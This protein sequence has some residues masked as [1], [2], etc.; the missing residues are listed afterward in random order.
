[1]KR[2]E[3][4]YVIFGCAL[5]AGVARGGRAETVKPAELAKVF[6]EPPAEAR[7]WVFW[8]W[9][10]G[11]VSKAGITADLEAMK[12]GGVAGAYL[13]PI[14]DVPEKPLY[15]P[16][17]RTLTPAWWEM[18]R[19]AFAEADRL[20][21]RL[22]MQDCDGFATAGGPWITPDL[23]MQKL[24]WSATPVEGGAATLDVALA[25]PATNEGFYR[26]VAVLAVPRPEGWGVTTRTV[27]P[28][29]T[30]SFA[31]AAQAQFLVEPAGD[32]Q[33]RES[34]PGWVQ[35]A[36]AEP[37]TL[38]SLTIR[39]WDHNY[40]G[41]YQAARLAIEVSDDGKVFREHFRLTPPR[42][43]WQDW[44]A[45]Y[46]FAVP[47]VTARYF[48]FVY[49][50][51]GS[52]EGSEELDAAKWKPKL[53]LRGLELSAAARVDD[54][55]GK[56]GLAWRRSA[57]TTGAQLPGKFCVLSGQVTDLRG[58]VDGTG[59]LRWKA[60]AGNWLVLRFGYT[61]TGHRNETAG[62][63]M[64]LEADKL[65]GKAA[66][67]QFE[68][69]F[70][71]TARRV[72][73]ELAARVLKVFH[74][75]SWEAG[76]QN[77]TPAFREEFERRRGFDPVK[78]LPVMAGIGIDS[79]DTSERFL[80]QVRQTISDLMTEKFFGTLARLAHEHGCE[81]SAEATAPTMMGD[82]MRH[83]GE[84]DLP[85]GEFWL[86]S[87][88][89]DKPND[90]ADAVSGAHVY[91]RRIAQAEAF[92]EL[93]IRWDETPGMLKTLADHNFALGV[94]RMVMHV[95][96][97]NPWTD[98]KPGMTLSGVGTYF[99]RDQTWWPEAKAWTDYLARCSALLQ[100]GRPVA[101]V[102]YFTGEELPVRAL[103]PERM[104]P[105]LPAGYAA[106]SINRDALLRLA[107]ADGGR[108]VLAGGT[109]YAVLV[110]P[111]AQVEES[112]ALKAK[113]REL[114]LGGVAVVAGVDA[115]GV[116]EALRRRGIGE[117]FSAKEDG[118]LAEGV[119]WT[120]RSTDGA[121]IYF[122]SNQRD[123]ERTLTMSVR[124]AAGEAQWWDPVTGARWKIGAA[125]V[126]GRLEVAV[127]MAAKASG[128]LVIAG[129]GGGLDTGPLPARREQL[130]GP[131][132]VR[133]MSA[134]GGEGPDVTMQTLMDWTKAPAT[135]FF[136]GT[137]TYERT[138]DWAGG[139]AKKVWLDVGEVHDLARAVV[140]GMDCG[141]V[142]TAPWRVEVTRALKVGENRLEIRVTN[143]WA[144]RLIGDQAKPEG[145]RGTWTIVPTGQ[146][147]KEV[148][149]AG[150]IGPVTLWTEEN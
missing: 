99:Q 69:W 29:V 122:V 72:G 80:W 109:S 137:A 110:L 42:Q 56:S 64:G 22:G 87:P 140:N 28:K 131:W 10:Q 16:S 2:R 3:W 117:D 97:H 18:L 120:H 113:V 92:T 21:I 78:W 102:A 115:K 90:V 133:F 82:G 149:P 136:S 5:L 150:L 8:Y 118:G 76:S 46:T 107:K 81:F 24:V 50:P 53:T 135:K 104:K 86:R 45:D 30:T 77:W 128:F 37:F 96:A 116:A 127:K 129:A 103:L 145:E 66:Q 121:E 15:E 38:R 88:T 11:A 139:D 40:N 52:E 108:M 47:E 74:V 125:S 19:Y 143:T 51:T 100:A 63:G 20:G 75:D 55:E 34:E 119:E 59:R 94:N 26:D 114:E 12:A 105:S 58:R 4:M 62:A 32:R 1:M 124:A 31:D 33:L 134:T 43:G 142:W 146:W 36:F 95:F 147:P 70:G 67:A 111:E 85:M 132:R 65:S 57:T 84:A 27:V 23:A 71:E 98:R 141:V 49:D 13:M 126:G 123:A 112:E 14:K 130:D 9:M 101:D 144:N 35:Y 138:F 41:L 91:G 83:F 7:P 93:R 68:G 148:L 60:P 79:A 6:A 44:D 17:V 39:N 48:R 25:Q 89:H 106:D 73:P 61:P 54:F